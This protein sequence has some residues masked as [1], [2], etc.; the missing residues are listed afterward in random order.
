[1]ESGLLNNHHKSYNITFYF[2]KHLFELIIS[3]GDSSID[4]ASA[5]FGVDNASAMF[6]L[7]LVNNLNWC[8]HIE[9]MA[10]KV[11]E[12]PFVL[13]NLV[14]LLTRDTTRDSDQ[15]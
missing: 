7:S 3:L 12:N 11:C 14:K 6:G 2:K 10:N 13:R 4:N 9:K 15:N 8:Y 5:M 1:M